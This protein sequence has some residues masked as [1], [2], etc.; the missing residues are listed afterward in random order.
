MSLS[1]ELRGGDQ[2][3]AG[4]RLALFVGLMRGKMRWR[5]GTFIRWMTEGCGDGQRL[6]E[7]SLRTF[8]L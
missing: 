4:H 5:S 6:A 2:R 1:E 8:T 7:L 3:I